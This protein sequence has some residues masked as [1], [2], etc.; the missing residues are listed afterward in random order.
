[1]LNW[2]IRYQQIVD[3]Y[4]QLSDP[5]WTVLEIE[6]GSPGIAELLQREVT[7][8][9]ANRQAGP[10]PWVTPVTGSLHKLPFADN[11]FDYV[12]CADTLKHLDKSVRGQVIAELARVTRQQVI[13]SM[14]CGDMAK[15]SDQALS[16]AFRRM[17]SGTPPWLTDGVTHQLPSV[18]EMM[19]L[20]AG[21]GLRFE[22]HTNEPL[23]QHYSGLL[24]DTIFPAASQIA[25]AEHR[26]ARQPIMPATGWEMYYSY[27]F[28]ILKEPAAEATAASAPTQPENAGAA[29]SL[30]TGAHDDIALYAVYHRRLPMAPGTGITPIYVGK[31]ASEAMAG[32]RTETHLDNSRWSELSGVH[33]VWQNGPRS[34]LV[35]F[36]HYRRIFD[37]SRSSHEGS[38]PRS[39]QLDYARYV[40]RASGTAARHA[41]K[42]FETNANTLVVAPPLH[43]SS[44]IWDHYAFTHNANDLCM[45]N[46]LILSRHPPLTPH[47][48]ASMASRELYA[49]NLFIAPWDHFDELCTLWFDVLGIFERNVPPRTED[50]YQR[51][52]ISFL[53]ERVF[54]AWVRYRQAQGTRLVTVPILEITYPG[55]D[56][57]A[58][59]RSPLAQ[60]A[61]AYGAN[62]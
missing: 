13:I 31:A 56:I 47:L 2:R 35:G 51:R 11:S 6:S 9:T 41:L 3:G 20:L 54:D 14:P 8:I 23:L 44:T 42:Y 10:S 24:L 16:A 38:G 45:L 5:Q 53:A 34:A 25:T 36:C 33:D 49:N 52:D 50:P 19:G 22:V 30:P 1:M 4:P 12:I 29:H 27:L 58:W 39:I 21:L 48:I 43:L 32:E 28:R 40:A 18:A 59:T 57:S 26:K 7:V 17:G 62:T 61:N 15:Q 37:F 55:L 60:G 46:N